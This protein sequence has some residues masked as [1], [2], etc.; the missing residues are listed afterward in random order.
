MLQKFKIEWRWLWYHLTD[1]ICPW[2]SW[3]RNF[4]AVKLKWMAEALEISDRLH[5]KTKI[6]RKDW[7]LFI[8][9]VV[10]EMTL[11]GRRKWLKTVRYEHCAGYRT[12]LEQLLFCH[13][14]RSLKHPNCNTSNQS[15]LRNVLGVHRIFNHPISFRNERDNEETWMLV[16]D[17]SFYQI[18]SPLSF[19]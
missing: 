19:Q 3:K 11:W 4:C 18:K 16:H 17:D 12:L 5:S 9:L 7:S 13:D 10:S 14:L 8:S 2:G 15:T 6:R 1:N